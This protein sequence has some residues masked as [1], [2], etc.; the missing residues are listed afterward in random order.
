V[1]R[2]GLRHSLLLFSKRGVAL[3]HTAGPETL[4]HPT[5]GV[6][7]AKPLVRMRVHAFPCAHSRVTAA[8]TQ[9]LGAPALPQ[10]T[11]HADDTGTPPYTAGVST[12][13]TTVSTPST[14]LQVPYRSR[15]RQVRRWMTRAYRRTAAPRHTRQVVE[16][17]RA[18]AQVTLQRGASAH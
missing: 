13:S 3:Q 12:H 8:P 5:S 6:C 9:T 10:P 4:E 14:R 2:I 7:A 11:V 16:G 1:V 18:A 15:S 17:L